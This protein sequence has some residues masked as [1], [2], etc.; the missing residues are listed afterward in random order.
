M[1]KS[2]HRRLTD[3]E[4]AQ[5]RA[6]DRERLEQAARELLT[7]DGWQ[8]WVRVRARNGLARYSLGNQLLIALQA[9]DAQFVAGFHGWKD[10]GRRVS[11]GQRG[12]RILAPMAL[13][14]RDSDQKPA[15]ENTA[16]TDER[17]R[18]LFKSVAV[19]D[20]LSRD[21]AWRG[22]NAVGELDDSVR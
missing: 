21:L 7:S 6:Q 9:P 5:R 19:F 4:R 20:T 11:K 18:T 14:A 16:A 17:P 13:R 10:L 1:A 15:E 12:I 22:G 3:D 8:R 2:T